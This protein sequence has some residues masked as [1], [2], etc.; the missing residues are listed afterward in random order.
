MILALAGLAFATHVKTFDI[1][2]TYTKSP[3]SGL[4]SLAVDP[5]V[6]ATQLKPSDGPFP[7]A[8]E[9]IPGTPRVKDGALVFTNPTQTWA[10]MSINGLLVGNIG[11][12]AT[13]RFEGIAP[14]R[15]H[16]SLK[17]PTGFV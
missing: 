14:G 12:Y 10:E 9:V 4:E 2:P 13:S 15:Y 8:A 7:P 1:D 17:L 11:P 5:A 6:A 3:F 16:V